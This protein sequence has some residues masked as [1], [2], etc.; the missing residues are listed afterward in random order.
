MSGIGGSEQFGL[1][2]QAKGLKSA[3]KTCRE[4]A[5]ELN[6]HF[7]TVSCWCKEYAEGES[8]E[9][10]PRSGRPSVLDRVSKIVVA[11][12]LTKKRQS[13]RKLSTKLS[14]CGHPVTHMTI[15]RYLVKDLGAC[16]YRRLKIP[17]LTEEHVKKRLKFCRERSHWTKEDWSKVILTDESPIN[18]IHLEILRTISSGLQR[19]GMLNR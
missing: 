18:H 4:T 1:R 7:A 12:S 14:N 11:K 16:A 2:W 5:R 13:T 17:K 10:K 6:V 3:G 19:K 9:D 8:L 15:Q